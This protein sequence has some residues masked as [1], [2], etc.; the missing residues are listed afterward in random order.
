MLGRRVVVGGLAAG[1][2]EARRYR[3]AAVARSHVTADPCARMQTAACKARVPALTRYRVCTDPSCSCSRSALMTKRLGRVAPHVV[4]FK[5]V[6]PLHLF[7]NW[8]TRRLTSIA[9]AV[10]ILTL[11]A[12][13][14]PFVANPVSGRIRLGAGVGAPQPLVGCV[15]LFHLVVLAGGAPP[16]PW[17][18]PLSSVQ[19][20]SLF[21]EGESSS[22][23]PRSRDSR[24][25]LSNYDAPLPSLPRSSLGHYRVRQC[26]F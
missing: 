16:A 25:W 2:V 9:P 19:S 22:S 11:G 10:P 3:R 5:F 7:A 12:S 24:S 20:L 8:M 6:W 1:G 23:L 13:C 18:Q 15:R 4:S 26:A 21:R 14:R 17:A